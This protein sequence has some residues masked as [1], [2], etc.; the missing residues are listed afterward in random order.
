MQLAVKSL[1]SKAAPLTPAAAAARIVAA[2]NFI[3]AVVFL[4]WCFCGVVVG[5]E[6]E[7]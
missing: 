1:T 2:E 7:M 3:F 6:S 4:R 5:V